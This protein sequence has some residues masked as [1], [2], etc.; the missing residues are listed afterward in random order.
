MATAVDDS[1]QEMISVVKPISKHKLVLKKQIITLA[2]DQPSH[3]LS[4]SPSQI[5]KVKVRQPMQKKKKINKNSPEVKDE[6]VL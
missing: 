6:E 5:Q 4:S 2:E 1:V 3:D